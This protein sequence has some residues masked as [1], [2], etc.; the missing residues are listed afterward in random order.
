MVV[1]IL[2]AAL[3]ARVAGY[4]RFGSNSIL[5]E[6]ASNL[7]EAGIDK[8]IW[9]LNQTAGSYTG[10]TETAIGTTGSFSVTVVDK[11]A[12]LK[13]ITST[14]FIPN[15]TTPKA[16]RT[17][18]V[19]ALIS[20]QQIAFHYA[21]QVGAGGLSMANSA[22]INGSVYSNGN[23]T[24]SGSSVIDGEAWAVGTI[25]SPDPTIT[26][27][28]PHPSASP[29][30][31]P[32]L[33]DPTIDELKAEAESGGVTTCSPACN[34]TETSIGKQKYIGDLNITRNDVVEMTSGPIYVTGDFTI[35]QGQT[36]LKLADSF[37]SN[38]SYIIV[39][40]KISQSQGGQ[41]QPTNGNP[42]GY[43]LLITNS[44][45]DDA[46]KLSQSG[47]NAIFYALQGGA[48]L[49]QSAQVN[50]LVANKLT[51][52]NSAS[53]TYDSGLTSA[54]F[55]SG[56]GGSWQIKRGSYHFTINP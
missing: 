2:A 8:A 30:P 15:A 44:T 10:E 21:V 47:T 39:D 55:S 54:Q 19:D 17:I 9:Q 13:T 25:S 52:Q 26:V 41:I 28:P 5:R 37:G 50:T 23:I 51:M 42:K 18:K 53:L 6:Q 12:S 14:G 43:I 34:I 36:V 27:P 40:G 31:M 29:Q 24:G 1:L 48:G 7:A 45:A 4:L 32:A 16:K 11:T 38:G 20:S 33:Q 22:T 3:F 35:S 56:P 46:I 49:S